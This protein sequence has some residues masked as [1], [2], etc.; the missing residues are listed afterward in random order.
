MVAHGYNPT[1]INGK[2]PLLDGWQNIVATPDV[3]NRWGNVGPNTGMV[4]RDTPVLD[5]D[6][7]NEEAA[8]I[9]EA[10]VR[11]CLEDNGQILVRVGLPPKRAILLRTDKPFRKILRKLTAPDGTVHKI[12]VLGDGQQLAVAGMHPDTNKP[13]VW[14]GGG[15][16]VNTARDLLPSADDIATILNLCVDELKTRLGWAETEG[17]T[18]Q[19]GAIDERPPL[20]ERLSATAYQGEFGINQ[21]LLDL[22]A[23][24]LNE[25]APIKDVIAEC[26]AFVRGVVEKLDEDHPKKNT[27]DWHAQRRQIEDVCYGFIKKNWAE[28]P[29]LIGTLPDN[30]L[31]LWRE[32]GQRGGLPD[33]YK[34]RGLGRGEW[35]VKDTGPA[36][37]IPTMEP[38]PKQ[39]QQES[40]YPRLEFI[41]ASDLSSIPPREFY[42]GKQYQ[43]GA[44]SGTMAPGGRGKSSLVLVEAVAM[45]VQRKLLDDEPLRRLKVWYHNGEENWEELLRRLQAVCEYY[46][47]AHSDLEN[48]FCM[49]SAQRF[50]LRVAEMGSSDRFSPDRNLL[51]HMYEEIRAN[52][53]DVICLDPLI[54][55]HGVPESNP[56]MMR[57]VMDIFRDLAAG[58]N[59]SVEIVGH[60]RK[61][62]IGFDAQL[63]AYDTRGSGAI[64]DALRSVRMLD[65]MTVEEAEKAEVQDYE[66]ERHVRVTPAKRNY[67]ATAAPSQWI[68]IENLIINNGDDVGV[69]APWEWPGHDPAAFEAAVQRAE[70]IFLDLMPRLQKRGQRFSDKKGINFA[71]KLLA[72]EPEAKEMRVNETSLEEAM[73][74][75]IANG[76]VEVV[77][78]NNV[79]ELRIGH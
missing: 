39:G 16:P 7:L 37:E 10:T 54:T 57:G 58:I 26:E 36:D 63:T 72:N 15:S 77:D 50:P 65:L 70:R 46:G 32:I 69:V 67:S 74:R 5:I 28:N 55:L 17:A 47:I 34:K 52:E 31:Q 30:L 66:R 3:V 75:L 12:E 41:R 53:Y 59:C 43:R 64:V 48:W 1:P 61:P 2:R 21:A 38:P 8:Q 56:V 19:P 42:L 44:V 4:T 71:P 24:R 14:M 49:T 11:Q 40:K 62:P 76:E 78:H 25:G 22:S 45:A 6:I 23:N 18:P 68:R 27:W 20:E 79:H 13:Y 60:T 29:R 9:V 35:S 33:L 73:K 51:A